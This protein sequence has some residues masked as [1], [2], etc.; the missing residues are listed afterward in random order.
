ML[1]AHGVSEAST[2]S[3]T[4]KYSSKNEHLYTCVVSNPNSLLDETLKKGKQFVYKG[5]TALT[6]KN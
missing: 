6:N 3:C 1:K 2:S 5:V 4:K